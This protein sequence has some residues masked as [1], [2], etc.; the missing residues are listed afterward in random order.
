MHGSSSLAV[1]LSRGVDFFR[2]A[3]NVV[4]MRVGI[5]FVSEVNA[6]RN[7]EVAVAGRTFEEVLAIA[8]AHWA[9]QLRA[10]D[11]R[12]RRAARIKESADVSRS[13]TPSKKKTNRWWPRGRRT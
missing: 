3:N 9:E 5:S 13:F 8:T 12:A 7:M 1:A 6:Q 4:E 2:G 10:I 11:V